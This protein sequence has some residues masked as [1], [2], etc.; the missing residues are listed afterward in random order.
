M[1]RAL[2]HIESAK[3]SFSY[4]I[5]VV[6]LIDRILVSG[7]QLIECDH[8]KYNMTCLLIHIYINKIYAR[9]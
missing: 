5:Q 7:F 3:L 8:L 2:F 9:V 1:K 4:R 6:T